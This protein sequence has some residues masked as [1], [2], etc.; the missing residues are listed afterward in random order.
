[1]VSPT[2]LIAHVQNAHILVSD[3]GYSLECI[4]SMAPFELEMVYAIILKTNQEKAE[5]AKRT[6]GGY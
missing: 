2:D 5:Q 1:M 4:E 6:R 3:H